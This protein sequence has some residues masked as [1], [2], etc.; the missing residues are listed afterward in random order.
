MATSKKAPAKKSAPR[1]DPSKI[2][3]H[4]RTEVIEEIKHSPKLKVWD[5]SKNRYIDIEI[6]TVIAKGILIGIAG[7]PEP[8]NPYGREDDLGRKYESLPPIIDPPKSLMSTPPSPKQPQ[9]EVL[10]DKVHYNTQRRFEHTITLA[11]LLARLSGGEQ[12]KIPEPIG[13]NGNSILPS[14]LNMDQYQSTLN[15]ITAEIMANLQN[16]L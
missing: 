15:D 14:L 2:S 4:L 10:L 9:S 7:N 8:S 12:M 11:M 6:D 5:S 13:W 3:G 16:I 1:R